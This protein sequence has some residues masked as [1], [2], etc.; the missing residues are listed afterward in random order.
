MHKRFGLTFRRVARL[1]RRNWLEWA[2]G[3]GRTADLAP[4]FD[5]LDC[6]K[7]RDHGRRHGDSN[8]DG[9]ADQRAA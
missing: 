5:R 3:G 6:E 4:I 9:A 1:K 2:R 8:G 7:G